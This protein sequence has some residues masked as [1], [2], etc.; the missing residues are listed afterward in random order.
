MVSQA[1][2]RVFLVLGVLWMLAQGSLFLA[3]GIRHG[4]DT[5]RYVEGAIAMLRGELP[6]GKGGSYLGYAAVVATARL[7]GLGDGGIILFQV[8][9]SGIAAVA[10]Y[11]IGTKLF[12]HRT[13]LVAALLFLGFLKLHPWN[14]FILT[15]SLFISLSIISIALVLHARSWPLSVLTAVVLFWTTFL[16]PNG[17]IVPLAVVSAALVVWSLQKRFAAVGATILGLDLV[18]PLLLPVVGGMASHERILLYYKEGTVIPGYEQLRVLPPAAAAAWPTASTS[19]LKDL[20]RIW[21][22]EPVY[23]LKLAAAKLTA[24]VLTIRPYHHWW[25]NLLI[26]A[27]LYPLY[28]LAA[29][30]IRRGS[31]DQYGKVLLLTF[32]I[33]QTLLVMVTFD[34]WSGRFLLPVLPVVFVFAAATLAPR[35]PAVLRT[36]MQAGL[37]AAVPGLLLGWWRRR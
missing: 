2:V 13:G 31:R 23:S 4:H 1:A 6:H 27:T 19:L 33:M 12:D 5:P 14:F 17:F 26:A 9:F 22:L 37:P 30:G 20:A 25:Y 3:F 15:D 32:V 10:T 11:A 28:I 29:L 16:R 18:A 8:L 35:L 24:F 34:D 36:A 21:I 7:A